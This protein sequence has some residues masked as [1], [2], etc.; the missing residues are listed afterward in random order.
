[1]TIAPS[2]VEAAKIAR[3]F[4][5]SARGREVFK[6]DTANATDVGA[7]GSVSVSVVC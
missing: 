2:G 7:T 6:R 5:Q 4:L 3:Y 1:M